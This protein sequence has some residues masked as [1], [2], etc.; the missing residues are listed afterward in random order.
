M[1]KIIFYNKGKK[2]TLY[3]EVCSLLGKIRGLMFRKKEDSPAL[4]LFDLKKPRRLKI[5]S[6]FCNPFV[7]VYLNEKNKISEII[8]VEKWRHLIVPEKKFSKLIEIP[9]NKKYK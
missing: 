6:F 9:L 8:K 5:H 7:A 1:K 4:L 2:I 3:A